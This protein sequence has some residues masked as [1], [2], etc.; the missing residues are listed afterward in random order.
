MMD[1][2]CDEIARDPPPPP[3]VDND[4]AT[5][6]EEKKINEQ[7]QQQ[8]GDQQQQRLCISYADAMNPR[9]RPNMEDCCVIHPP[10][11]WFRNSH[12]ENNYYY[13]G[14]YDGHGGTLSCVHT[15]V[16]DHLHGCRV[17]VFVYIYISIA[18]L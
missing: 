15:G 18:C 14:V 16:M 13:I 4:T 3:Q 6:P 10:G 17:C 11:D 1:H 12:N 5:T 2:R 7:E 9:R 8:A